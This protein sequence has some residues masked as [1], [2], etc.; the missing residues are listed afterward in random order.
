MKAAVYLHA[1]LNAQEMI[2]AYKAIFP[3]DVMM[4]SPYEKC[5]TQNTA[6][7]GKVFHAELKIGDL[8][9]Y[10]ADT[11]KDP[12]FSSIDLIAEIND[13]VKAHR[14]FDQLS[15]GGEVVSSFTKMPF[16]P[17]IGLVKD[18]FGIK[19]DIVIC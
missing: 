5:M 3:A 14:I 16:G 9:L 17:T 7:I 10:L 13:E 4:N 11:G 18:K 15:E 1:K 6:L 12:D 8:N 19:W 2:D